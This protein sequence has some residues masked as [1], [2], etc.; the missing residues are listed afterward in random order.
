MYVYVCICMYMYVYVCICIYRY[1]YIYRFIMCIYT[2]VYIHIYIY[3]YVVCMCI[4]VYIYV[5]IY[6]YT[7]IYIYIYIY[8]HI[9]I[10]RLSAAPHS[11]LGFAD[12]LAWARLRN[13]DR[14]GSSPK[15]MHMRAVFCTVPRAPLSRL[16]T[17]APCFVRCHSAPQ[18]ERR[19]GATGSRE[20][21]ALPHTRGSQR[22]NW[23]AQISNPCAGTHQV[24]LLCC[25]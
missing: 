2:C 8:T 13:V 17:N 23:R 10:E 21:P 24:L 18:L 6:I 22:T 15:A 7:Y 19:V 9:H 5:Y 12:R 4:C 11:A 16:C 20:I 1:I 14:K 3:I 25:C